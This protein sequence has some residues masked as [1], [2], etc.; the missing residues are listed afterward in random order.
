V[1]NTTV[2][3]MVKSRVNAKSFDLGIKY[4]TAAN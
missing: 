2:H 3:I 4:N 1:N